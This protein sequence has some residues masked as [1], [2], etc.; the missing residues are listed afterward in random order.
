MRLAMFSF[1]HMPPPASD[2]HATPRGAATSA[3]HHAMPGDAPAATPPSRRAFRRRHFILHEFFISIL[4]SR[5]F[6]FT[7]LFGL[8]FSLAFRSH[9]H[10]SQPPPSVISS[11]H[12][13]LSD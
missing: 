10:I 1:R 6:S 9:F 12:I 7:R 8:P 3:S 13:L 5:Y 2:R 11:L 4:I